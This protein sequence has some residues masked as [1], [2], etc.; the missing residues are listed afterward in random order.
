MVIYAYICLHRV[1]LILNQTNPT[2]N[3]DSEEVDTH[4]PARVYNVGLTDSMYYEY[5]S[6]NTFCKQVAQSSA[7]VA[8][9]TL[10]SDYV[11]TRCPAYAT[12]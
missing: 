7:P 1:S 9:N 4:S 5:T 6:A 8:R 11:L 12:K 10:P 2:T 3:M